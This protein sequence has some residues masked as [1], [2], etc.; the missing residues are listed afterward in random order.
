MGVMRNSMG[1]ARSDEARVAE[2]AKRL[3]AVY[4]SEL[5]SHISTEAT[6][7]DFIGQA[8]INVGL[9]ALPHCAAHTVHSVWCAHCTELAMS[10]ADQKTGEQADMVN[11]P[12]HYGGGDNPYE[13]IK[14]IEAWGLG[15]VLGNS[16]KYIARAGRKH[17]DV[18]ED[19]EKAAWYLN[20]EIVR[21]RQELLGDA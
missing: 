15:F 16:V 11:H 6:W 7:Q 8:V 9:P 1:I 18:L 13:V 5:P 20:H 21:L 12:A 19:L 3:C 4:V 17:D 2:E 14:V 10:A